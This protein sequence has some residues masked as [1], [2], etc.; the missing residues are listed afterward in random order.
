MHGR[1]QN[2]HN[3]GRMVDN[4]LWNSRC[5]CPTSQPGSIKRDYVKMAASCWGR[6]VGDLH[7]ALISLTVVVHVQAWFLHQRNHQFYS[8]L[9][10]CLPRSPIC[11]SVNLPSSPIC[12][13]THAYCSFILLNEAITIVSGSHCAHALL[14]WLFGFPIRFTGKKIPLVEISTSKMAPKFQCAPK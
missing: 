11:T 10:L 2:K 12:S 5:P 6:R 8:W 4:C 13:Y 3:S 7:V 1:D 9:T 14:M